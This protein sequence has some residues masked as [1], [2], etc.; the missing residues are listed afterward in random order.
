MTK[1]KKLI[2]SAIALSAALVLG[3]GTFF[4]I[5]AY[6]DSRITFPLEIPSLTAKA[7]KPP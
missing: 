6:L 5:R 2:I 1:K 3:L 4:G 7:R